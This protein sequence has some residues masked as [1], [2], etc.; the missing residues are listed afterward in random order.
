MSGVIDRSPWSACSSSA[1]LNVPSSRTALALGCLRERDVVER[2][3]APLVGKSPFID[4][5]VLRALGL[6]RDDTRTIEQALER[7]EALGLEWHAAQT[8]ALL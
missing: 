1:G 4:P 6:V 2:K 8:R 5:F 7:F 3:A